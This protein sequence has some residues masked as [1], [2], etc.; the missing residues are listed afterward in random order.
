MPIIGALVNVNLKYQLLL[1]IVVVLMT[2]YIFMSTST[3]YPILP[4]CVKYYIVM[5]DLICKASVFSLMR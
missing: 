2:F 1:L 4:V 5:F 3:F